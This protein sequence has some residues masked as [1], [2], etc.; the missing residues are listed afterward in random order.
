MSLSHLSNLSASSCWSLASVGREHPVGRVLPLV[1]G[2]VFGAPCLAVRVV[3][4][5]LR[6]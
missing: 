6:V 5:A 3:L 2:E 1:N 4:L